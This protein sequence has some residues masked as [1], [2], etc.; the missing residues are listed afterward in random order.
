MSWMSFGFSMTNVLPVDETGERTISEQKNTSA[1]MSVMSLLDGQRKTKFP[2]LLQ[3]KDLLQK[4]GCKHW[5]LGEGW[6]PSFSTCK[7]N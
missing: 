4:S 3:K 2:F 6:A 5:E 1:G 7:E